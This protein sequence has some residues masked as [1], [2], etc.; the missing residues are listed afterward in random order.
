MMVVITMDRAAYTPY[1]VQRQGW[2]VFVGQVVERMSLI[3]NFPSRY[4]HT[5]N[6]YTHVIVIFQS[7]DAVSTPK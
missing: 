3:H 7:Y 5:Y 4:V 2:L 6:Y 1:N